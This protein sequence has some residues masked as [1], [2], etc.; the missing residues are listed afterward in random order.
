MPLRAYCIQTL[1]AHFADSPFPVPILILVFAGQPEVTFQLY[2]RPPPSTSI[3][4]PT[5]GGAEGSPGRD[6]YTLPDIDFHL[7]LVRQAPNDEKAVALHVY[8]DSLE[9]CEL[10][11]WLHVD[12]ALREPHAKQESSPPRNGGKTRCVAP[13]VRPPILT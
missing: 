4:A 12:N 5:N 8:A 3:A 2:S 11:V 9:D 10:V 13:F 7:V 6:G 1:M